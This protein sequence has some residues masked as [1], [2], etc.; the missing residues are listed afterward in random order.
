MRNILFF[1][2]FP[3]TLFGFAACRSPSA[4]QTGPLISDIETSGNVLVI[5]DCAGTSVEISS[6]VT[7]PSGVESVL[8]W[9]RVGADQQFVSASMELKDGK[10]EVTLKGPDFLGS[11][12]GTLEFYITA[13]DG[14]GNSSE[15]PTDESI[16]FLPC[17]NN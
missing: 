15:S 13:R 5:S 17:V 14:V 16:E 8:L 2:L 11:A 12:Y 6:K 1:I 10:Y 4:D 7:D 3:V 9:H